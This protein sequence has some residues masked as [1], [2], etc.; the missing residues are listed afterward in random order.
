MYV[1]TCSDV[2]A[3]NVHTFNVFTRIQLKPENRELRTSGVHDFSLIYVFLVQGQRDCVVSTCNQ[4]N[5][6]LS[7]LNTTISTGSRRN[8]TLTSE[9]DE[10]WGFSEKS[11]SSKIS[12]TDCI[13][14]TLVWSLEQQVNV[15]TLYRGDWARPDKRGTSDKHNTITEQKN[16]D[17]NP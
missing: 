14:Q 3:T 10:K 15:L 11:P 5:T 13:K 17:I 6:R 8:R 16:G 12:S 9:Q 2:D 4:S 7:A 1:C